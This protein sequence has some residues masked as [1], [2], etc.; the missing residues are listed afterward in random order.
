M[1]VTQCVILVGGLGTRLGPLTATTP[2]PLLRVGSRV[3]L[4]Y[5]VDEVARQGFD[6]VVCLAG[7]RATEIQAWAER[8]ASGPRITVVAEPDPLGTAGALTVARELLQE[9]FLMLNGD[10]LF[11]INLADFAAWQ[12]DGPW[13]GILALRSMKDAGRYGVVDFAGGA[14]KGFVERPATE[15]SSGVINAGVYRLKREV[16]DRVASLPSSIERDIFPQVARQGLLRGR[17]YDSAFIDIGVPSSLQEAQSFLPSLAKRPALFLDRDGVLNRDV[18][19]A[20]R[21]EQIEWFDGIFDVVKR[22]NDEGCYV[23]VV[24]NQAGVARGFYSEQDV[25]TLHA[26][27]NRQFRERGAYV[28]E[29]QYCPHHPTA[30]IG[31]YRAT[32][33]CRKPA[34]G[35]ITEIARRWPVDL[36]RSLLVG[37]KESDLDAAKNAG[38]PSILYQGGSLSDVLN[39]WFIANAGR[40][41]NPAPDLSSVE[42]S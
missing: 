26:W 14:I 32:C 4:D 37:D 41:R 30:G 42:V 9:E 22:A 27:M 33:G 35:M 24:T 38:V 39:D 13:Q 10:S 12:P 31:A 23:F 6:D 18:D 5:L 1:V 29:F 25:V 28:D 34:P 11:D 3:F 2:K 21:P 40:R 16:V 36:P 17:I 19:Y 15:G 8:R 7:Y 20:F